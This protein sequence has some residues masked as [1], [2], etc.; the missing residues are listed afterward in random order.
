MSFFYENSYFLWAYVLTIASIFTFYYDKSKAALLLLALSAFLLASFLI[1]LDPFLNIWDEQYHALVAK[2][3]ANNFFKPVLIENTAICKNIYWTDVNVWLHKQPFFLWQ[4]A[5][6]IKIFGTNEIAVRLP[7]ALMHTILVFFIYDCGK[8]FFSKKVSFLASVLFVWAYFFCDYITGFYPSDHNDL[9]FFFYTFLSYW[10]YLKYKQTNVFAY[11]LLIGLF[12]G[13]AVLNKWLIGLVIYAVWSID[14][15]VLKKY[16]KQ[17]VLNFVLSIT[18]CL[19]IF[20]PWQIYAAT[21][22]PDEYNLSMNFN[23]KHITEVLDGHGGSFSFYFNALYEQLG[24]GAILPYLFIFCFIFCVFKLKDSSS[25]VIFGTI[26]LLFYLFFTFIVKT[27]ML[28]YV[29]ICIPFFIYSLA[30]TL[31]KVFS[32]ISVKFSKLAWVFLIIV[33]FNMFFNYSKIYKHHS[34]KELGRKLYREKQ[35][36]QVNCF[37]SILNS[38]KKTVII[39]TNG[40]LNNHVEAMFY[41]N[42]PVI[43]DSLNLPEVERIKGLG[44]TAQLIAF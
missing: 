19:L 42:L 28:G 21:Y 16:N 44:F 43:S 26:L 36:K 14:V 37:K 24:E 31:E 18:A 3:L 13:I 1:R 41:S 39:T 2:H 12:S 4:I 7:S 32:F 40:T 9:A 29:L 33:L 27:K 23:F 6:S 22:Y 34:N 5:L 11:V 10:A 17:E 38:T 30:Y 25:R 35:I 8:Y 15:V 20:L